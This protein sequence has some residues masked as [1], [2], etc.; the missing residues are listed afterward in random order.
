MGANGIEVAQDD[1][2]DVGTTLHEVLDDFLVHLLRVA[3]RRFGLL[4]GSGFTDGK[5]LG[6]GLTIDGAGGGED[7]ALDVVLGHQFEDIDEAREIVA[8]VHQRLF[9]RFPHGL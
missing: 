5:P 4:D 3:I 6:V 2:G 1:G 9:D 8:I 7:D